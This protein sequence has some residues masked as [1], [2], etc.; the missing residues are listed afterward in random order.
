MSYD[1]PL[2]HLDDATFQ[3]MKIHEQFFI[4]VNA[5]VRSISERA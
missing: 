2:H 1:A 5:H 4:A 3:K